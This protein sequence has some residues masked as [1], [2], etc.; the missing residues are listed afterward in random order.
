MRESSRATR[1]SLN[2]RIKFNHKKETYFILCNEAYSRFL[3]LLSLGALDSRLRGN[4]SRGDISISHHHL[5]LPQDIRG[6]RI[7]ARA[8]ARIPPTR[9]Y[10]DSSRILGS[11]ENIHGPN[12]RIC[13]STRRLHAGNPVFNHSFFV[14]RRMPDNALDLRFCQTIMAHLLM[15][16][17]S[18]FVD[19][20]L[21]YDKR[22]CHCF[23]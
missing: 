2:I 4:D 18:P 16:M 20:F 14:A 13:F 8:F 1:E 5:N 7:A 6:N 19:L 17:M 9:D 22:Y 21:G 15:R 23:L 3:Y 10:L 11:G 12:L